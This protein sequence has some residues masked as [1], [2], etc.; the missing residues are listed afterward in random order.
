MKGKKKFFRG[1]KNKNFLYKFC[2]NQKALIFE[3]DFFSLADFSGFVM[4]IHCKSKKRG[5]IFG[6]LLVGKSTKEKRFDYLSI[7]W[8]DLLFVKPST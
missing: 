5:M 8:S 2:V 6:Y 1:K 4:K 3:I 7:V